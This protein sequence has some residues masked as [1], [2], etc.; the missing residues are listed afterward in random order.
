MYGDFE[1]WLD[2]SLW[3]SLSAEALELDAA[4]GAVDFELTT[5]ARATALRFDVHPATV[6]RNEK[7]TSGNEPEKYHMELTLPSDSAYECG[8]YLA[9]LPQNTE[10]LVKTVLARFNLPWDA[11]INI[12][13]EGPSALP[14]NTPT[15]VSEILRSYVE[16]SQP[17]T[18]KVSSGRLCRNN[19][20][21]K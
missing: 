14:L 2:G 15:P 9:V 12:K 20:D 1:D 8:D 3:P 17:V 18:K 21:N 16:L 11:V 4:E 7:L 10:D 13:G 6:R 19:A 5:D